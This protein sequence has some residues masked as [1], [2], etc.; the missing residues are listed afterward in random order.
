M[1]KKIKSAVTDTLGD[2]KYDPA[3]QPGVANLI[4]IYAG[5]KGLTIEASEAHFK[6]YG[7]G[8]L[9]AEVADAV[10]E[11]M[12]PIQKRYKELM[13]NKKELHAILVQGAEK[14]SFRAERMLKKVQKK[15]GLVP[16]ESK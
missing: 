1:R 15:V 10:V 16:F 6:G 14:A 5:V 3:N 9:K 8:D 2:V 4:E 13:A 12:E 7:Y 11:V